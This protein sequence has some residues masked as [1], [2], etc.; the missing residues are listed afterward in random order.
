VLPIF[1]KDKMNFMGG[2]STM[3]YA[4]PDHLPENFIISQKS[5][6]LF[7]VRVN[8]RRERCQR[9][10]LCGFSCLTVPAQH[11]AKYIPNM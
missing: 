4:R 10:I 8:T 11:S 9:G 3:A 2:D 1:L 5:N 6:K 7:K